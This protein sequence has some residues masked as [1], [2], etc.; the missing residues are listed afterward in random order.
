[1]KSLCLT[2]M[3]LSNHTKVL[4][5][6]AKENLRN[7]YSQCV[8]WLD[9]TKLEISRK[10]ETKLYPNPVITQLGICGVIW[11]PLECM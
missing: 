11:R 8:I 3:T 4:S 1:M 7:D 6:Y 2:E 5:K 9:D 10:Q